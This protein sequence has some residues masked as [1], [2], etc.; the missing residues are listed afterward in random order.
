MTLLPSIWQAVM[1]TPLNQLVRIL[2]QEFILR[3]SLIYTVYGI[4]KKAAETVLRSLG[5]LPEISGVGVRIKNALVNL[6]F[7]ISG[8]QTMTHFE[9]SLSPLDAEIDMPPEYLQR[10]FERMRVLQRLVLP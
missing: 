7:A 2:R 5:R 3:V 8:I 9:G 6:N 1:T 4:L 10:W